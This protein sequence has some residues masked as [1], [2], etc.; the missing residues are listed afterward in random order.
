MTCPDAHIGAEIETRRGTSNWPE[1]TLSGLLNGVTLVL[2]LTEQRPFST[3][4]KR[5]WMNAER[6]APTMERCSHLKRGSWQIFLKEKFTF[7]KRLPADLNGE[8]DISPCR[9]T[10]NEGSR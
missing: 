10:H 1:A 7:Q 5:C 3:E 6:Q 8:S 9:T 4:P 2:Q